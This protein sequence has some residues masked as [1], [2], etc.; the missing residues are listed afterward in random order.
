MTSSGSST[1]GPIFSRHS[2]TPS[3][4]AIFMAP[5]TA[6][7]GNHH[8]LPGTSLS[9]LCLMPTSVSTMNSRDSDWRQWPI[10]PSVDPMKSAIARTGALHSGWAR[11]SASGCWRLSASTWPTEM[12]WC[13]GQNPCQSSMSL[14]GFF[15]AA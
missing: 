12:D 6:D 8:S 15:D 5:H 10:I 3:G 1:A 11:T 7:S 2:S 9:S 4:V 13:M 14:E